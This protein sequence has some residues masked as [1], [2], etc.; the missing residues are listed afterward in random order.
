MST[1][2]LTYLFCDGDNCDVDYDGAEHYANVLRGQAASDGWRVNMT[3]KGVDLCP[4]CRALKDRD[5]QGTE[6]V[7]SRSGETDRPFPADTQQD[8]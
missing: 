1:F 7:I 3:G 8:A 4:D 5:R 6:P 2:K